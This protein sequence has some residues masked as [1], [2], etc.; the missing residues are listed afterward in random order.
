LQI[1][2]VYIKPNVSEYVCVLLG[3]GG[4]FFGVRPVDVINKIKYITCYPQGSTIVGTGNGTPEVP[5]LPSAW[6]YSW[7]TLSLGVI[8]T[9]RE[10]ECLRGPAAN[11]L[12]CT[13][14][15]QVTKTT[16][17]PDLFSEGAP[18]IEKEN[19]NSQIIINI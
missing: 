19:S 9:E 16:G 18:D 7:A 17:R 8:N 6:G 12:N 10:I 2:S 4:V 14:A 3:S 1:K 13:E 15:V 5:E 11:L